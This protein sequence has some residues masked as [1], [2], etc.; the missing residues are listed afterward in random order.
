MPFVQTIRLVRDYEDE[1]AVN[2]RLYWK[3]ALRPG[4]PRYFSGTMR[5][6][7]VCVCEL[8]MSIKRRSLK[9]Y[10]IQYSKHNF[11]M[12]ICGV[13]AIRFIHQTNIY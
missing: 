7:S 11:I 10:Y 1:I 4:G 5:T 8:E 9:A 2:L 13:N 6:H 12:F 3:A